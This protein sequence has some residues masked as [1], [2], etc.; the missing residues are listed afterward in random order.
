MRAPRGLYH[1]VLP[2]H[3]NNKLLFALCTKCAVEM[4]QNKCNCSNNLTGIWTTVCIKNALAVGYKILVHEIYH[5]KE[6]A[7][8]EGSNLGLFLQ[9]CEY[10]LKRKA[11]G[12]NLAFKVC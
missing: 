2:I 1:P 10:V 11:R 8:Y 6:H 12:I 7:K 4:N 3:S 5:F 9:L